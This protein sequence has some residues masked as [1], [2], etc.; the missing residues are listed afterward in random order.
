MHDQP[1]HFDSKRI[2]FQS[3]LDGKQTGWY[4]T[5]TSERDYGPF[6]TKQ[7]AQ[8]ILDGLLRRL[9]ESQIHD[10]SN[11]QANPPVNSNLTGHR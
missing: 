1:A 3:T 8:Y 11:N 5:V 6:P 9:E 7:V 4:I 2:F 10:D